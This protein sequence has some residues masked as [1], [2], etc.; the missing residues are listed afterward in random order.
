MSTACYLNYISLRLV[1]KNEDKKKLNNKKDGRPNKRTNMRTERFVQSSGI[2]SDGM[3]N[4]ALKKIRFERA[5][6]PRDEVKN[7]ISVPKIKK[8]DWQVKI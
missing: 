4:D 8:D 6:S 2:F 3:G 7:T 5:Y 1:I